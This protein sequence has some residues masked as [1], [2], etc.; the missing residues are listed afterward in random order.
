MGELYQQHHW[1]HQGADTTLL[2]ALSEQL[3]NCSRRKAREALRAGLC[4]HNQALGQ[5]PTATV[6]AGDH[7]Q[8]DLRHGIPHHQARKDG[9]KAVNEPSFRVLHEDG[10]LIIIDKAAGVLSAPGGEEEG[11]DHVLANLRSH[12]RRKG[13]DL[14]Y[15]GMIHRI[16]KATSGCLV[17]AK[18]RQAQQ[19]LQAQ[20]VGHGAGRSYTALVLGGPR[21]DQDTIDADIGRGHDGRRWLS[22][23]PTSGKS[24]I[25]HFQVEERFAT[26]ARVQLQ[27][28]TGRTHQI[29]IHMASIGC[30]VLGDPLYSRDRHK[31][32][33]QPA[34]SSR[35]IRAPRLMLHAHAIALDHPSTGKRLRVESP[36]P[37]AFA[38]L[39]R[40][41]ARMK[42]PEPPI[43]TR[44][45]PHAR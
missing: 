39:E 6:S 21:Q 11:R 25:T 12:Y 45:P 27:L 23:D 43:I 35:G 15:L 40:F 37:P 29:R 38:Q 44:K 34:G 4:T 31:G 1:Q 22:S 28:D 33:I 20:F 26:A 3:P 10:A 2:D 41:L 19:L 17:V 16:D 30:P 18:T 9:G 32:R 36:L 8:V 7:L 13:I 42:P 5:D 14:P 24:A